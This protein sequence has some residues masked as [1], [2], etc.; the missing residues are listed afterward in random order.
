[1]RSLART[2]ARGSSNQDSTGAAITSSA[3]WPIARPTRT[4]FAIA[5]ACVGESIEYTMRA[6]PS[7]ARLTGAAP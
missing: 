2:D 5:R 4:L 6:T 3:A 1:M 7:I